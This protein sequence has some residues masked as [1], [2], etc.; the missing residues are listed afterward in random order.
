MDS[1]PEARPKS[2]RSSKKDFY[3][4][5]SYPMAIDYADEKSLQ[6]PYHG[7]VMS[8]F[9]FKRELSLVRIILF[10]FNVPSIWSPWFLIALCGEKHL[11][12]SEH[13]LSPCASKKTPHRTHVALGHGNGTALFTGFSP[14]RILELVLIQLRHFLTT[15]PRRTS[16][17]SAA[18][19]L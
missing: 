3:W 15:K 17:A 7:L 8:K 2:L 10:H 6:K 9:T 11:H 19:G 12:P 16:A 4:W 14:T 13:G 18:R 5:P 1:N